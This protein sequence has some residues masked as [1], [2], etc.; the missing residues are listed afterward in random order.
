MTTIIG[1]WTLTVTGVRLWKPLVS[2][3]LEAALII[4]SLV[5]YL[6]I[7]L[8]SSALNFHISLHNAAWRV[9]R[10]SMVCLRLLLFQLRLCFP[11]ERC[12]SRRTRVT[13]A[14]C[15]SLWV[16]H[17]SLSLSLMRRE[18]CGF[19]HV[20][21]CLVVQSCCCFLPDHSTWNAKGPVHEPAN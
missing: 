15:S 6:Y 14:P 19:V 17:L 5:V 7:Y 9:T 8:M 20:L 16:S 3:I 1:C 2:N 11:S 18:V 12:S 10:I 21:S 4:Q 13:A